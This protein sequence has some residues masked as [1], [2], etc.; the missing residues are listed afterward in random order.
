QLEYQECVTDSRNSW[1]WPSNNHWFVADKTGSLQN[2]GQIISFTGGVFSKTT[3]PQKIAVYEGVTAIS[4]DNGDL[5]VYSNGKYAWNAAGVVT[6]TDIKEGDEM[7][8]LDPTL[9]GSRQIGSAS[10]GIIAV[11]HPLTPN[12]YYI[13]TV[14]DV[15]GGFLPAMSYNIFDE[16]GDEIQGNTSLGLKTTEGITSTL[17][18]N[19]VD[20]WVI[21]QKQG[22][23]DFYS[24]LLTCDGFN[25]PITSGV[26]RALSGDQARGGLAV[27]HDGEML[28]A[29][30]PGSGVQQV[31]TYKF[32]NSTGKL[33]DPDEIAPFNKVV[34]A[35]DIIFSKDN[36]KV[37]IGAAGFGVQS[38]DVNT[39]EH[40]TGIAPGPDAWNHTIEIGKDGNYY[41]NGGDGLWRWSG[42][43][44][45]TKV[46]DASGWGLPTLYIPPA[47]EPDIEEVGPF[48]DTAQIIDLHT[49]WVCSKLSAEDTLYQRHLYKGD[50]IVDDKLGHFNPAVAGPGLHEIVFTYCNVNDTILIEVN[51]CL[52]CRVELEE[53]HPE[54]CVGE[55]VRLDTMINIANGER[56]WSIDSFP[57]TASQSA[58]ITFSGDTIFDATD[59]GTH[60]GTYKLMLANVFEG[61]S[62]FDSIYVTVNPLPEPDLGNDSTICVDWDDVTFDAGLFTSYDWGADGGDV[63]T[64][65]KSEA[66]MYRVEVTD[67]NGCRQKDSVELFVNDLPIA[68]LPGDT[69]ICA[70]A[71]AVAIDASVLSTGGSGSAITSYSWRDLPAGSEVS[72][73]NDLSTDVDGE[74]YVAIEDANG[75]HDTDSIVLTVHALPV[76]DLRNDTSIC[77]GDAALELVTFA[78]PLGDTTYTWRVSAD[79]SAWTTTGQ[80]TP[81]ISVDTANIYKVVIEDTYGCLDSAEF[82]LT[83]N[84]LPEIVL[85]DS[86]ICGDAPTVVWNAEAVTPGMLGYQW[87]EFPGNIPTGT[88]AILDT[89]VAGDYAIGI[90]DINQCVAADTITLTVNNFLPVDLGPDTAICEDADDVVLN[91]G[92][93][94]CNWYLWTPDNGTFTDE[95]TYSVNTEAMY[96]VKLEDENGCK[97]EDSIYVTV[98]LLPEVDLGPD[99]SICNSDPKVV[100]DAKN[101]GVGMTYSWSTTETTQTIENDLAGEYWVAIKDVKGC[102]DSDTIVLTVHDLPVV[103]LGDDVEI[104]AIEDSVLFNA[105]HSTAQSWVWGHGRTTQTI[106]AKNE[107][108]ETYSVVVTDE[109]GCIG[110]DEVVL[111]VSPMPEV[112]IRDSSVCIDADDVLFDVGADFDEYLWSNGDAT[113]TSTISIAGDYSVTFTTLEG[114]AGSADFTLERTALPIPDLGADQIICADASALDFTPGVFAS[115]LWNDGKT[116]PTLSTKVA[117]DYE[118]EVTDDKGCKASDDVK[119]TVIDMPTPD[120][121]KDETKCPGSPHTFDVVGYDNGNGPYTYAWDDGSTASTFPTSIATTVWVDITDQYG[122]TGRDLGSVIDKSDLT[123]N[124]LDN[125]TVNLCEGEDVT[126]IPN[127]KASDGYFFTWSEDGSGT[128][129]T[130]LATT[131]GTYDLH[132]DNG[133]GC[134]GDGTIDVIVHLDPVLVPDAAGICDGEAALIGGMNDLGGT[135]TYLWSTGE[136]SATIS[137]LTAGIY[138]Q[139]VTSN[140]GCVSEE[141]VDV[142]V[143]SN[144]TPNI[145]GTTVCQGVGVTLTDLN[146]KGETTDFIWSTGATTA[147]ISPT[148]SGDFTL[149]VVDIHGCKGTSTTAVTFIAY[150]IVDLGKDMVICEGDDKVTFDAGNIGN[151]ITW[152]SG[153]TTSTISTDQAGEYIVTVSDGGCPAYDTVVLSV[154]DLP[155]SELD[156]L[157]AVNPYCFNELET[158]ILLEA[159]ARSDYEYLWGTGETT[160]AISVD[161]A[162][163]YVVEISAG[164]CSITDRIKLSD[165]C[166]STLYV[167]NTFTPDGDGINDSFNAVGSYISDYQMFIYN[168]WG[169]LIYKT[170]SMTDDWDGTFMGQG[171]QVDTYVYKIYY[172]TNHPDGYPVNEQKVGIVNLLR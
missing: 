87:F 156:Q 93:A 126:L 94:N 83:I 3:S 45:A 12:K 41:L 92:I 138:T 35:Y 47:E 46:D 85:R 110:E 33:S 147:T 139:E 164:T 50:G 129:E 171:V 88:G 104:C 146:D 103:D 166:P 160:S 131:T 151:T 63:Q 38:I 123:V 90:I 157:L 29:G 25:P 24:Y 65:T 95:Q 8:S 158:A 44:A 1:E 76:V 31:V 134:E 113:R 20:I 68:V 165:Y 71:A 86:T 102:T 30:F 84:T 28:A 82:E 127:F 108:T 42:S 150:P 34:G 141:T 59:L 62:C 5:V 6:S 21:V 106:K 168:R 96:R 125:L 81:S 56:I 100:F 144:P 61:D 128:S 27:S 14:G 73:T 51:F 124:I 39:K 22:S 111:T 26:G 60:Y 120:I 43:G 167:P 36:S 64:I 122:C 40:K 145:Q 135:Y 112:T 172:K 155:V 132:V 16:N 109:N 169:Q 48:C 121:I 80:T 107:G 149:D 10:Q 114:C 4:D 143:Y 75:C 54:I 163:T 18:E 13:I 69:F 97:G 153:Q 116:T 11:R 89:K 23:P 15:I 78:N 57:T 9:P 37:I 77:A 152:N 119:L 67:A 32:N 55:I 79:G 2:K 136:T 58:E 52:N 7:G 148:I 130:F 105:G 159:G 118:V 137:V 74:Y 49:N 140:Q 170:E 142:D 17:H 98:N 101:A 72:T 117:G 66:K 162:G 19:G 161:A 53:E 99:T 133:G 91:A 70:G 115:Y 154:V